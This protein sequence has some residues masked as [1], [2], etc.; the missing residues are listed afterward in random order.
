MGKFIDKHRIV[1]IFICTL[2][3]F[4]TGSLL[5]YDLLRLRLF[6]TLLYFAK[7]AY[8]AIQIVALSNKV[9]RYCSVRLTTQ[10]VVPGTVGP[11]PKI[12]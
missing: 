7:K 4:S 3:V 6:C 2:I 9:L 12:L 1:K 11:Y 5:F 8:M 10:A